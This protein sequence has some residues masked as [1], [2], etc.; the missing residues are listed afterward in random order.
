MPRETVLITAEPITAIECVAAAAD[1]DPDLGVGRLWDGGGIQIAGQ[2]LALAVLRS[3]TVE[4]RDDAARVFG[5]R[6]DEPGRW[7]TEAY[8]PVDSPLFQPL[9]DRLADLTGAAVYEDGIRT[10]HPLQ[11]GEER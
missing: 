6:D 5:L 10:A 7:M 4:V 8:G 9:I 2:D 11:R 3:T 1:V